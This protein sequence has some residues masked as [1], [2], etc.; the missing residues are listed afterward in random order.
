MYL[1][2]RYVY[3]Y[4]PVELFY[5][6]FWPRLETSAAQKKNGL[7]TKPLLRDVF[8]MFWSVFTCFCYTLIC[9]PYFLISTSGVLEEGMAVVLEGLPVQSQE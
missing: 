5:V 1:H 4:I 6:F 3:I 2:V 8:V 7:W 9:S